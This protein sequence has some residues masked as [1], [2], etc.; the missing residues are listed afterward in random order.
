MMPRAKTVSRRILPP[1]NRSKKPKI[2]PALEL[3]YSSQRC[4]L[5]PGVGIWLPSRYTASRPNA[6]KS[7]LRKSGTRKIF[8]NASKNLFMVTLDPRELLGFGADYLRRPA[9]LLDLLHGRFR[10]LVRFHRD[11]ARQLARAQHL[12][13][14]MHLFD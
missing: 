8:A 7:R 11:L 12:Q 4:R 6:N 2:E 3:M 10:K 5:M 9:R 1:A 14:V 13:A